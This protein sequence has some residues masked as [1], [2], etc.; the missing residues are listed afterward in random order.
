ME[1]GVAINMMNT[2]IKQWKMINEDSRYHSH[3]NSIPE[4]FSYLQEIGEFRRY[5]KNLVHEFTKTERIHLSLRM[6]GMQIKLYTWFP[7]RYSYLQSLNR[8]LKKNLRK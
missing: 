3:Y 4:K 2:L 8:A 6:L 5:T 7:I 1:K